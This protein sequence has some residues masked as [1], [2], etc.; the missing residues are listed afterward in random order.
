[1]MKI[2]YYSTKIKP[3]LRTLVKKMIN[4]ANLSVL[5]G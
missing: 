4:L 3:Y 5:S 2:L 1:M